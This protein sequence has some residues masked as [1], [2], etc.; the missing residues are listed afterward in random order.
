MKRTNSILEFISMSSEQYFRRI[1][2]F[3]LNSLAVL[4][5]IYWI[6]VVLA[7]LS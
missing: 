4:T 3:P 7:V 1:V 5:I 2:N 6:I